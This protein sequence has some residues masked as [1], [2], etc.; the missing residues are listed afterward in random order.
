MATQ[1]RMARRAPDPQRRGRHDRRLSGAP[2]RTPQESTPGD[3][4]GCRMSPCV[5]IRR[6]ESKPVP[7]RPRC[8]ANACGDPSSLR[9]RELCLPA[10]TTMSA[11]LTCIMCERPTISLSLPRVPCVASPLLRNPSPWFLRKWEKQGAAPRLTSTAANP[12]APTGS[13]QRRTGHG[14]RRYRR[15][16][17]RA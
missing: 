2:S 4:R 12:A 10:N 1:E 8:A 14:V 7:G 3:R 13:G 9:N 17:Q 11:L 16:P 15:N 5:S 6:T